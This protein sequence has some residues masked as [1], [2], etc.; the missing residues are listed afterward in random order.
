[1]GRGL[2]GYFSWYPL[3]GGLCSF[4]GPLEAGLDKFPV[5]IAR[6]K[7]LFP[8]RTEQSSPVAPM[9][10]GLQGPGRV[11][12][13]RSFEYHLS[14]PPR[15]L[16]VFKARRGAPPRRAARRG[17]PDAAALRSASCRAALGGAVPR[18][19]VPCRAVPRCARA[20][21]RRLR[22]GAPSVTMPSSMADY[23]EHVGTE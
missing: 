23:P 22:R 21:L 10:L 18:C 20:A 4:E 2:D 15:R 17:S 16:L 5:A 19:V 6:G 3:V 14:R 13:R 7:Y 8:F 9:V 1:M 11:G 12:R